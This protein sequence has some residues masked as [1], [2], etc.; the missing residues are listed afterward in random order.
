MYLTKEQDAYYINILFKEIPTHTFTIDSTEVVHETIKYRKINQGHL[1]QI[2]ITKDSKKFE[3]KSGLSTLL[4]KNIL[5]KE[6]PEKLMMFS[7]FAPSLNLRIQEENPDILIVFIPPATQY[8]STEDF[9]EG[10]LFHDENLRLIYLV[11][12]KELESSFSFPEFSLTSLEKLHKTE[13]PLIISNYSPFAGPQNENEFQKLAGE[14]KKETIP[15][16]FLSSH[17]KNLIQQIPKAYFGFPSY[18]FSVKNQFLTFTESNTSPWEV[19]N[20]FNSDFFVL[21]LDFTGPYWHILL[22]GKDENGTS[23]FER[24][25]TLYK[26]K[27]R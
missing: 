1:V 18:E 19:F 24:D 15:V 25:L 17:S 13:R 21:K 22:Q 2:P 7:S 9:F 5:V 12:E 8:Q 10:Q 16:I 4:H 20:E 27:L 6:N 3:I 23:I 11:G 26:T 14:L